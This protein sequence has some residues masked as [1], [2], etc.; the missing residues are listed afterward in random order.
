M[1]KLLSQYGRNERDKS[2]IVGIFISTLLTSCG[3]L[4][5][6]P[7]FS[8]YWP[9]VIDVLCKYASKGNSLGETTTERMKNMLLVMRY[10]MIMDDYNE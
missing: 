6:Q 2:L 9:R 3:T 5:K 10:V 8:S 1:L 7:G 4:T